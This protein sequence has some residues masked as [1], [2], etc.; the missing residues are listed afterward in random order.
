MFSQAI[1][2]PR[3]LKNSLAKFFHFPLLKLYQNLKVFKLTKGTPH[4]GFMVHTESYQPSSINL[5]PSTAHHL[6]IRGRWWSPI[7]PI[8][9]LVDLERWGGDRGGEVMKWFANMEVR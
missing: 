6:Y 5:H 2:A 3:S 7:P 1:L 8:S 9:N 4:T